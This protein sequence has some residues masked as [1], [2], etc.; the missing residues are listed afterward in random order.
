MADVRSYVQQSLAAGYT[1][2]VIKAQLRQLGYAQ[3]DIVSAF[4]R[5]PAWYWVVTGI[6]AAVGVGIGLVFLSAPA[7]FQIAVSVPQPT[8]KQGSSLAW[9]ATVSGQGTAAVHYEL[10][11]KTGAVL[12]SGMDVPVNGK[13][14][15]SRQL[16][17]PEALS[18]GPY[19]FVAE[20]SGKKASAN[21]IVVAAA[22][23]SDK[24]QNQDEEGV[25]CGG[26]CV[27]CGKP[28][29]ACDP[30]C[31]DTDPCTS[32]G[33]VNGQ[34]VFQPTV[35]CCG[36]G[37]CEAGETG[38]CADC[39]PTQLGRTSQ[40]VLRDA[41]DLANSQPVRAAQLCSGISLASESDSCLKSVAMISRQ[42][43]I[44]SQVSGEQE[45]D[46]CLLFF[47]VE[48]KDFS[49]CSSLRNKYVQSSCYSMQ[50]L[51]A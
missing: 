26:Q 38:T 41:Q 50:Q 14:Q 20:V 42:Q 10:R 37:V 22:T 32:D 7:G 16:A 33:C 2:E 11:G 19:V 4:S 45:H 21:I 44:C 30:E 3:E 43:G 17:I 5:R 29:L 34:C 51:S 1:P 25:D 36:N 47:A 49:S 24:L 12:Q 35:P 27:P 13:T 18:P 6:L 40:D 9:T 15:F 46:S 39:Q 23:C 8:V 48:L 28:V 31:T